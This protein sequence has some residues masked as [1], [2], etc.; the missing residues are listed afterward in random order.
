MGKH[1][2]QDTFLCHSGYVC[3]LLTER[4]VTL[5]G[6]GSP[7]AQTPV[8]CDRVQR[9]GDVSMAAAPKTRS[10]ERERNEGKRQG[11]GLTS[12][13]EQ[14]RAAGHKRGLR[15]REAMKQAR[16][17][18]K[19]AGGKLQIINGKWERPRKR[20]LASL[21]SDLTRG[22]SATRNGRAARRLRPFIT[23][24]ISTDEHFLVGTNAHY[25]KTKSQL[26]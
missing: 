26:N 18:R 16:P 17:P 8:Y 6:G 12:E 23:V 21:L 9:T 2:P 1:N 3:H 14:R 24:I 22:F 7:E 20:R 19:S 4:M 13:S 10:K 25:R 11:D 5:Q 15:T